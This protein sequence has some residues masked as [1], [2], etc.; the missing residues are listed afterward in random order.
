MVKKLLRCLKKVNMLNSKIKENK[1]KSP[2]MSYVDFESIIVPEGNR[3]KNLNESYTN[4]H[5]KHVACSFAYKLVCVDD[6]F[7]KHF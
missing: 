2:L 5:Q 1:I 6:K 7:S 3:K 4:K